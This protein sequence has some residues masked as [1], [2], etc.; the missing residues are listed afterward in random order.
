VV[1][2]MFVLPILAL[3]FPESWD[4]VTKAL[5]SSAMYGM[6]TPSSATFAAG[7]A[8]AVFFGHVAALL[9]IAGVLLARRDA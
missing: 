9:V 7:P 5:P 1:V 6:F 8:T 2:V 4:G 3:L